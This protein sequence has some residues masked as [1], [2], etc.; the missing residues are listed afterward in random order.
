MCLYVRVDMYL[1]ARIR[2]CA[3]IYM[4]IHVSLCCVSVYMRVC[5]RV[6]AGETALGPAISI[7]E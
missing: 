3:Y 7:R 1:C 6:S 5:E 2:V 4:R